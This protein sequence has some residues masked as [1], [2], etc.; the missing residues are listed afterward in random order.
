MVMCVDEP[1][2][3][4]LICAV[5]YS[6]VFAG[7]DMWCNSSNRI[8]LDEKIRG[9]GSNMLIFRMD[10]HDGVLEQER[11]RHGEPF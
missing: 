9:R 11:W 6:N 10:E 8:A 1:W 4:D 3:N 2:R 5:N 7:S